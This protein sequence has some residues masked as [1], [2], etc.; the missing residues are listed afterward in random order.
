[1]ITLLWLFEVKKTLMSCKSQRH[2]I[3]YLVVHAQVLYINIITQ[4]SIK[5]IVFINN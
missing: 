4:P 5:K 2:A 3:L 1:M